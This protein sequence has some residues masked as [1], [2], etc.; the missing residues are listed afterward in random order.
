MR[1]AVFSPRIVEWQVFPEAETLL[2]ERD[3]NM[4]GSVL[5]GLV[6]WA[7]WRGDC[8]LMLDTATFQFSVMK[9]PPPL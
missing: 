6:C 8:L 1:V 7:H 2:P 4:M 9:L 3:R 5:R